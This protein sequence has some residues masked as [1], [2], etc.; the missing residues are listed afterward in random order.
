MFINRYTTTA[1][2]KLV[3]DNLPV[4]SGQVRVS[5]VQALSAHHTGQQLG[6]LLQAVVELVQFLLHG[7][8]A[9]LQL[10]VGVVPVGA[11]V[12]HDHLHLVCGRYKT[13]T[14]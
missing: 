14:L 10:P 5:V 6:R 7:Q 13:Q 3:R 9:L 8:D 11:K 12:E 4:G 1:H 2:S